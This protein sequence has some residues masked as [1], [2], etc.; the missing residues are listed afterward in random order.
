MINPYWYMTATASQVARSLA[1]CGPQ[2]SSLYDRLKLRTILRPV[3]E[4]WQSAP[5]AFPT[6]IL[7][8]PLAHKTHSLKSVDAVWLQSYVSQ[9]DFVHIACIGTQRRPRLS[10]LVLQPS[11]MRESLFVQLIIW[12]PLQSQQVISRHLLPFMVVNYNN[13]R[14]RKNVQLPQGRSRMSL[15]E[16]FHLLWT[17]Q[18]SRPIMI[19]AASTTLVFT[20]CGIGFA[21]GVYQETYERLSH[22]PTSP[23]HGA[24]PAMIDLIGTLAISLMTIG[25]PYATAWTKSFNPPN[26]IW[27][28]GLV[29]SVALLLASFSQQTWHAQ[30]TQGFLAGLGTCLTY[31][32]AVTVAPTWF[33]ARRG[34]AMGIVLSGTGLG[35]VAWAPLLH[36]LISHTGWRNSLRISSAISFVLIS[37][38]APILR[39][40][41]NA[42]SR[43]AA[44]SS[45]RNSTPTSYSAKI[46]RLFKVPLLDFKIARSRK[47]LAQALSAALQSAAYYTPVFFFASYA[48][49]LGYSSATAS[50]FI[51]LS[52]AANAIGKIVLGHIADRIGRLNA[53]FLTTALSAIAVCALWIPSSQST[54]EDQG[55]NLFIA[56]TVLYGVF[57]SAY[58]ALF[59]TSLIELFGIQNFA[60]VNGVLYM[61]RGLATLVGTPVAGALI[62]G[63]GGGRDRDEGT[64]AGPA[65]FGNATI[66]VG[67]LFGMAT[68]AVLWVRIEAAVGSMTPQGKR[69]RL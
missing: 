54:T 55:R 47:F 37:I 33:T 61:I 39:W 15:C 48:T 5:T 51:A 53:L 23:F 31:M 25:A 3:S 19:V 22:D 7:L 42:A 64:H 18:Y 20:V 1:V 24:S 17:D 2:R 46:L 62:R 9:I 58:V 50:N 28:G 41:A 59:P 52:N 11:Q 6:S 65:S 49:T 56:F 34:L 16:S 44:E 60:S 30:L 36:A 43:F 57:A 4:H 13:Y 32:P 40:E 27:C 38:A 35:G 67:A 12:R 26:V 8:S 21:F 69:W 68:V 66:L 45:S 29:F 14:C 10:R 63:G